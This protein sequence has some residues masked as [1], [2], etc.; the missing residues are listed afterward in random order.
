M[1]ESIILIFSYKLKNLSNNGLVKTIYQVIGFASI[2][3]ITCLFLP[4][5]Y[6]IFKLFLVNPNQYTLQSSENLKTN[7]ALPFSS[8]GVGHII[9]LSVGGAAEIVFVVYYV[10]VITFFSDDYPKNNVLW[11][12]FSNYPQLLR[13]IIKIILALS[14]TVDP[15]NSISF[16][17]L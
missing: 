13:A 17:I 9:L 15:L 11:S 2:F 3:L 10:I 1:F 6:I 16:W 7:F 14:I 4:Y 8:G 5:H 12:E